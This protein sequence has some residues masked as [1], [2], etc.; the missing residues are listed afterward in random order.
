MNRQET[1]S[2]WS[3]E[4]QD[5]VFQV[6]TNGV[7]WKSVGTND[8]GESIGARPTGDSTSIEFSF[9]NATNLSENLINKLLDNE[10]YQYG[11]GA[12]EHSYTVYDMKHDS[13]FT[14]G[15]EGDTKIVIHAKE[16]TKSGS[17]KDLYTQLRELLDA[18]IQVIKYTHEYE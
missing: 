13:V 10:N 5:T 12:I 7:S 16:T 8:D 6:N 14:I 3:P 4:L 11:H 17:I 18:P 15:R 1:I 9:P 2:V